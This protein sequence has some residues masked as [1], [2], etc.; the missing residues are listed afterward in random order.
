MFPRFVPA[1]DRRP[2]TVGM[3][4]SPGAV[5]GA[6]VFDS[7]TAVARSHAGQRVILVRRETNADDLE[8]MIAAAG[9]RTSRGGRTSHAA[10]VAR[11]MGLYCVCGGAEL[12]VE[13][14]RPAGHRARWGGGRRG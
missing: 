12:E 1:P 8:G 7:P 3:N 9:V 14:H 5:T 10:V 6:V 2:L 13:R 11:G 4:A